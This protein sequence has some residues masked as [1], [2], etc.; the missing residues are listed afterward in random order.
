MKKLNKSDAVQFLT[1]TV[2][3]L[4]DLYHV[5]KAGT[6]DRLA[7]LL[8]DAIDKIPAD[9]TWDDRRDMEWQMNQLALSIRDGITG[10]DK[11]WDAIGNLWD[12]EFLKPLTDVIC[13]RFDARRIECLCYSGQV[14]DDIQMA[15]QTVNG[16]KAKT[17]FNLTGIEDALREMARLERI[18]AGIKA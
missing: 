1:D 11:L 14:A 6:Q 7:G 10:R 15:L 4:A 2:N 3:R 13:K 12:V 17:I 8:R 18:Y 9:R 5:A 16:L